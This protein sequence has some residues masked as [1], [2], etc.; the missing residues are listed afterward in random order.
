MRQKAEAT[1][2]SI[3]LIIS[4]IPLFIPAY[5]VTLDGPAHA[6]NARLIRDLFTGDPLVSQYFTWNPVPE[7]NWSGHLFMA[8]LSGFLSPS[9]T[10]KITLA[11]IM[12]VT[13]AGFRRLILFTAPEK[14]WF[15]WL[16]FPWLWNF[17]LMMGFI[18]YSIAVALM[19]WMWVTWI[20]ILALPA[21]R[22]WP[23]LFLLCLVSYFSHLMVFGISFAGMLLLAMGHPNAKKRGFA[24]A[25]ISAPFLLA[26]FAFILMRG[27]AGMHDSY[28]RLSMEELVANITNARPLIVYRYAEEQPGGR[29]YAVFTALLLLLSVFMKS[30]NP[31]RKIAGVFTLM[32]LLLHFIFPDDFASGGI[33]TVRLAQLFFLALLW[34]ITLSDFPLW[35]QKT[36][37]VLSVL[38]SI[39]FFSYHY[40]VNKQL[41]ED[42]E[43]Y[44]EAAAHVPAGSVVLPLNHSGNWLHSNLHGF[45]AATY[46]LLFLDNY[47][48]DM[49]HFPLHWKIES[50]E[51]TYGKFASS[52]TP[53][54]Y[55]DKLV[56][57]GKLPDAVISWFPFSTDDS[58][59]SAVKTNLD[60]YYSRSYENR[61]ATVYL[62]KR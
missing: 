45:A 8:V 12:V 42:A 40:S 36:S 57:A 21:H 58:C 18:N 48:A 19:P 52:T 62:L 9:L 50:P 2:F 51:I 46:P 29:V 59:T 25:A 44:T 24:L 37:A 16:I 41:S 11:L 53:C 5:F 49:K 28:N 43:L 15:S 20:K 4:I 10:M 7:P 17:P 55:F 22:L 60:R 39:L 27:T 26:G 31:H 14:H 30:G 3:L 34:W 33:I 13:A 6:Y 54:I 23:R 1:A 56:T 47:E 61:L 38:F 35:L 32:M